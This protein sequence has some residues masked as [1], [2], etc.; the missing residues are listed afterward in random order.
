MTAGAGDTGLPVTP[1]DSIS[2]IQAGSAG[3]RSLMCSH[4]SSVAASIFICRSASSGEGDPTGAIMLRCARA[5]SSVTTV[6]MVMGYSPSFPFLPSLPSR[7]PFTASR[8]SRES[9]GRSV[10]SFC[11]IHHAPFTVVPAPFG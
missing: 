8:Q 6:G 5:C 7:P 11:A 3:F 10:V 9:P 2:A 1:Q 4:T